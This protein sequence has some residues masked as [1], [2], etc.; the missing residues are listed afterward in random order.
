[1]PSGGQ[2]YEMLTHIFDRA[3]SECDIEI[4]F[5]PT[6]D[7]KQQNDCR[8]AMLSYARKPGVVSGRGVARR[9]QE[10]T[11][12]RSGLGLL[13]LMVGKDAGRTRLVV[14]RFPADQGI[15]AEEDRDRL[16]V[17]FIERVFMKNAKSYKSAFYEDTSLAR[18]FW[19]GRAV[20]RQISGPKELADY[21]IRDFLVSE[22]RTTAAA[23]TKRIAVALRTASR[24]AESL[25]VRQE[26]VSATTLL[27]QR[28]GKV[29]SARQLVER[30]G[31]SEEAS[32]ALESQL[33]R[34]D[35]MD[36]V[37]QFD[38]TEFDK[39]V[40]YRVVEVDNGGM[41]IAEDDEFSQIFQRE[42]VDEEA[43]LF[44]FSTEGH[45]VDEKLRKSR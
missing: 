17:E 4:V 23:G 16:S 21:W 28:D 44:R 3:P 33:P 10:V 29:E 7:G 30:L 31:L 39:H 9:L 14:S 45:I 27:R 13:F 35:L 25:P 38:R 24:E 18:G 11:T 42:A 5:R 40:A 6:A 19:D 2:L 32:E 26:L 36:E 43:G 1:M 15:I 34:A 8:D 41:M 12:H 22:L 20:D 37:F